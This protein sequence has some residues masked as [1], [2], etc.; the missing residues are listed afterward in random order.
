MYGTDLRRLPLHQVSPSLPS[1]QFNCQRLNQPSLK[2]VVNWWVVSKFVNT[3]F[4]LLLMDCTDQCEIVIAS[5]FVAF[6]T[7]YC[8]SRIINTATR[9]WLRT[10]NHPIPGSN[11][12]F[13]NLTGNIQ[14]SYILPKN[15]GIKLK[16]MHA[17]GIYEKVGQV[18]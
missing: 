6:V 12:I 10:D 16:R 9:L 5:H 7:W 8:F 15:T 17:Q 11:R 2:F 14:N 1:I 13:Q 18:T 4:Q 3:V